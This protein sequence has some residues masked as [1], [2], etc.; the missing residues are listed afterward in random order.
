MHL[1]TLYLLL[2]SSDPVVGT[3]PL[4]EFVEPFLVPLV[5]VCSLLGYDDDWQLVTRRSRHDGRSRQHVD[6]L[7][8]GLFGSQF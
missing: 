1:T 3:I 8:K 4:Q 6:S 5:E 7:S 2:E